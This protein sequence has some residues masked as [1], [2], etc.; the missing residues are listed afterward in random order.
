MSR[1]V[2]CVSPSPSLHL[3][4]ASSSF[5]RFNLLLPFVLWCFSHYY[6]CSS[7]GPSSQLSS[8]RPSAATAAAPSLA[9][10]PTAAATAAIPPASAAPATSAVDMSAIL[11]AQEFARSL[12][13]Q[14]PTDPLL[15]AAAAAAKPSFFPAGAAAAGATAAPALLPSAGVAVPPVLA[16]GQVVLAPASAAAGAVGAA[17]VGGGKSTRAPVLRLDAMG[18][19]ID[20]EGRVVERPKAGPVSSLKVRGLLCAAL[21]CTAL[22][23]TALHCPFPLRAKQHS[24][25]SA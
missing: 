9:V 14:M 13:F 19:E 8:Q 7:S 12:G 15:S 18:R 23:C 24:C 6:D 16:A 22:H 3:V 1:A 20:E 25:W 21:L 10:P 11:K 5:L 4:H 17:A 2:R